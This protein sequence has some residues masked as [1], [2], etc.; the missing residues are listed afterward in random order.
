MEQRPWQLL[1]QELTT[2]GQLSHLLTRMRALIIL[3]CQLT[4]LAEAQH[5]H[6]FDLLERAKVVSGQSLETIM[7]LLAITDPLVR[8]L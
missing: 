5:P 2:R 3:D 8:A 7:H 6:A 1:A 4:R